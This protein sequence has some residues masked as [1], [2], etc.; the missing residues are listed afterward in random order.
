MSK[1]SRSSFFEKKSIKHTKKK[2]I[3]DSDDEECFSEDEEC[4][5]ED[6]EIFNSK[7]NDDTINYEL[8][9]ELNDDDIRN[10][11]FEKI[12]DK[13]AYGKL[14]KFKVVM[15]I[16][17]RYINATKLCKDD[18]KEMKHWIENKSSKEMI[19][20]FGK[21]LGLSKDELIVKI[22]GG[23]L[24]KISGTYVHHSL[25]THIASWCSTKYAYLVSTIVNEYHLKQAIEEK[26]K[27]LKKKDDKIDKMSKKIDKLVDNNNTLLHKNK[28]I[29]T[30]I[31]R[32][33]KQNDEIY[34][35]NLETHNKLGTISNERVPQSG[36]PKHEH[37]LVIIKNNDD[38]DEYDEDDDIYDYHVLRVMKKS[39]DNLVAK[40]IERHPDMV[41]VLKIS[42]SPNSIHLWNM[43]K[44][45]L[46]VGKKKKINLSGCKFN[47]VNNYTEKQFK[48]DIIGIHNERLEYDEI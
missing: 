26:E 29:N 34:D 23:K 33:L 7:S 10:I 28:K 30:R 11:I 31:K 37:M 17:N 43:I 20:D 35:Q 5:S 15:M 1:S 12:N 32:L 4:F 24:T 39:Y 27:I 40:H 19:K 8:G 21:I 42:Y 44:E 18:G 48:K 14:G 38:P 16:E 47:L 6:E 22:N 25:I 46:A 45:K 3:I 36:N 13:F 2:I 41:I 9:D